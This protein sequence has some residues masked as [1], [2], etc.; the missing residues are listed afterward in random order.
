MQN[1]VTVQTS[2]TFN[3]NSFLFS[4]FSKDLGCCKCARWD[5]ITQKVWWYCAFV[6]L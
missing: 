2:Y 6:Q 3:S 4:C 1:L 5:F